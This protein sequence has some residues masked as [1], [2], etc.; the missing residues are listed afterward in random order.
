MAEG[1]LRE[2]YGKNLDAYSA[3]MHPSQVHP[4]A[5]E[6]M[7]ERNIDLSHHISKSIDQFREME[8]DWVITVCDDVR[9]MCPVFPHGKRFLHKRFDD[10]T[11]GT[12]TEEEKRALFRRVRDEIESF[13]VETFGNSDV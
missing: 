9:E 11:R 12:G 8:F 7:K 10:P 13:I 3:G 4:C 5:I 1:F 6:V 2:L